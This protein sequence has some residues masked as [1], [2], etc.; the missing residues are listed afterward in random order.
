M[1][2]RQ[3]TDDRSLGVQ[4]PQLSSFG[5]DEG[6]HIYA[7]SLDGPVYRLAAER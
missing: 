3:A 6:G 5:T 4:V 7:M 1:P 2:G